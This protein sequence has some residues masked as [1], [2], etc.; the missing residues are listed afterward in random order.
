MTKFKLALR[1]A[2]LSNWKTTTV[3]LVLTLSSFISFY[4]EGFG[5]KNS[6]LVQFSHF[7][8]MGGLISLGIVSKDYNYSSKK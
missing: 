7:I 1:E 6:L 4:P 8:Q 3:G 2:V 5:G